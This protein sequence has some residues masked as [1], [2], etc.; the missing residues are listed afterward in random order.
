MDQNLSCE[1]FHRADALSRRTLLKGLG[2]AGAGAV[3]STMFGDA[4]RQTAFAAVPTSEVLVVVSLRGGV[5]GLGLVVPHGDPAYYAARPGLALQKSALIC[6]D[7]MFGLHPQMAPLSW[8]WQSGELAAVQAVGMSVPNRSHF[9]AMEVLEEANP[10]SIERR[11]WVNRMV[12]LDATASPLEAVQVGTQYPSTLITGPA[13]SLSV[14]DLTSLQIAALPG[15]GTWPAK[16]RRQLELSWG[17]SS[18]PMA[19]AGA[20]AIRVSDLAGGLVNA[21]ATTIKYPQ[22]TYGKDLGAALADSAKL[23]RADI[24]A[25]VISIDHGTWDMHSAYGSPTFGRMMDMV[26]GLARALDAFMRDL[27]D[28]RSR[29]TVVTVS[30]FGRRVAENGNGGL[31]HGWGNM[32]LLLGGGVRGGQYYGSWPGLG[33]DKRVDGDLQVTTDYRNVFAEVLNRKFPDRSL[34]SVFPGLTYAPVGVMKPA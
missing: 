21:P 32:M 11:G 16:R 1:D 30:E 3:V 25:Q 15:A 27:G 6:Q 20:E 2:L 13:P 33:T 26:G 5:D 19:E 24:G 29:V 12:G 31:D 17:A 4:F 28:L 14:P 7:P 10:G 18:G 8:L 23:I 34:A 22:D 9:L